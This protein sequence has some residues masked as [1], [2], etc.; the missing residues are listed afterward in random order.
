MAFCP[1]SFH[2]T[3]NTKGQGDKVR[4]EKTIK[5]YENKNETFSNNGHVRSD[6]SKQIF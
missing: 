1:P 6:R 3:L 5:L 4:G 2:V